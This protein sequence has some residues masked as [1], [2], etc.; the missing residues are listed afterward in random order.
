MGFDRVT[1]LQTSF[2][3]AVNTYGQAFGVAHRTITYGDYDEGSVYYIASG[4]NVGSAVI[5]PISESRNG[6]DFQFLQQGM[7]NLKDLKCFIP[8]G[9]SLSETDLIKFNEGSYY[10]ILKLFKW[11]LEGSTVYQKAYIRRYTESP[12]V[13]ET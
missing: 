13:T 1:E 10:S 6:Q 4:G 3:E 5:M 12:V 8:S 9:V 11:R 2:N 7:I